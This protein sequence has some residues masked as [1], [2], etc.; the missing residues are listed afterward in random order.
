LKFANHET[1]WL[2][3]GALLDSDGPALKSNARALLSELGLVADDFTH[4]AASVWFGAIKQLVERDRPVDPGTVWAISRGL[5]KVPDDGF[6][7]LK[8]LQ[9]GNTATKPAL[10]A[11]AQ[12]LRRLAKLRQL[13]RFYANQAKALQEPGAQPSKLAGALDAFSREFAGSEEDFSTG[14]DDL[15]ELAEEWEAARMGVRKPF[16][17]TGNDV[18]D[19]NILGWEENLNVVGGPPSA[20][21]SAL[22]TTA[23]YSALRDG[24]RICIFGLE[25][26]TKWIAKRLVSRALGM[27][28]KSV[29]KVGLNDYQQEQTQDAMGRLAEPLRNLLAYKRGGI[30]TEQLVQLC[31]KAIAVH[32]VRAIFIDHGLEVRHEG[33]NKGDELRT[34]IQNTFAQL[35]DLAFTTHT[36]IVVVVHFNRSQGSSDG[37]P[38]MNQ[39]AECA[40]IER[41]ARLAIGLW[42]REKDGQDFVR[43][44]VIKQTEGRKNIHLLLKRETE[45]ALIS[46]QGGYE[47]NLREEREQDRAA[48]G[49]WKGNNAA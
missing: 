48:R 39:F 2:V 6:N 5:G 47:L 23:I 7:R 18:L 20:G 19:E 15:L 45:H 34:R 31:K 14:A 35:R 11:Y 25:D 49:G 17:P 29:G 37:P 3:L 41:M 30:G 26:G 10:A 42:E 38:T 46:P 12:E 1:E 4:P 44:T 22:L 9:T 16:L 13:E 33:Q 24:H 28:I 40:G 32:K 21:K 36:P 27:P 43:C 8:G